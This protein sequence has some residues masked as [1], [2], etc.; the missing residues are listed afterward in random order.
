MRRQHNNVL[1]L[2]PNRCIRRRIAFAFTFDHGECLA[3]GLLKV[4]LSVSIG[5]VSCRRR[6]VVC[7]FLPST[8]QGGRCYWA[9]W[10]FVL[11]RRC[12]WFRLKV[13]PTDSCLLDF[14]F[15]VV[16]LLIFIYGAFKLNL[17]LR[18]FGI[19]ITIVPG[20]FFSW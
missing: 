17:M 9:I 13:F 10:D 15:S 14:S 11:E 20:R 2:N 4:D 5:V 3:R 16:T 19:E 18:H 7:S 8:N 6:A 12:W 1:I